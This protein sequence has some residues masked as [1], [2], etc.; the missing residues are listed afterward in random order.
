MKQKDKKIYLPVL[1]KNTNLWSLDTG[2]LA[3]T[4]RGKKIGD[5]LQVAIDLRDD[6]HAPRY[7]AGDRV[8]CDPEARPK[9][10]DDVLIVVQLAHPT[11]A[12]LVRI[13]RKSY[14][15]DRGGD[16]LVLPRASLIR[17]HPIRA[18]EAVREEAA[19]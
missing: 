15:V 4:Q 1:G 13:N 9:V 10:G 8:Y 14:V 11:A 16:R 19:D 3:I 18:V 2:R 7:R 12:T 6:G 17:L 5:G